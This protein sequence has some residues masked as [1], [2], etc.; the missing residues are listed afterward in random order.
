MDW[1][2]ILNNKK[3]TYCWTDQIPDRKIIE[4][5]LE[6]VHLKCP[7]KQN[8]VPYSIEVL[9]WSNKERRNQI[10]KDTWCDSNTPEDRRNPQ[11]LAPY[12]FTFTFRDTNDE[13]ANS[14]AQLEIGLAAMFVVLSAANYGL[15]AGFCSCY[16]KN[17][18]NLMVGIGYAG[19]NM[20]MYWNPVLQQE[21]ETP[22]TEP[23]NSTNDD[24]IK[25]NK[26]DYIKF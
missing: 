4:Q 26:S 17:D 11:V 25:P 5:I 20:G 2:Q 1:Q 3:Q 13:D 19:E 9:D 24:D 23:G 16:Q 12:L 15:N 8:K 22:G 18:I 6:E 10:F 7:S 21:V 14:N